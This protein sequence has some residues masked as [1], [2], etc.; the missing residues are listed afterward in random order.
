MHISKIAVTAL[1]GTQ[2]IY[3]QSWPVVNCGLAHDHEYMVVDKKRKFVSQKSPAG[4]KLALLRTHTDH[5][6]DKITIKTADNK[7]KWFEWVPCARDMASLLGEQVE[8]YFGQSE[9]SQWMSEFLKIECDVVKLTDT[10]FTGERR[11]KRIN[12]YWVNISLVD[13]SQFL[14]ISQPTL[15][16]LS[17]RCGQDID[18]RR[19]RPTL[20]I[21]EDY[22]GELEPDCENTW[23]KIR[24]GE[25]HELTYYKPCQRCVVINVNQETGEVDELDL[26]SYLKKE[27]GVKRGNPNF[28]AKFNQPYA[29]FKNYDI[30]H[31][32]SKVEVL[33]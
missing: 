25:S 1:K 18:W 2:P 31:I 32:G 15:D 30:I 14:I 20:I 28:G 29:G 3:P 24:I 27:Q 10:K 19:F 26:L 22:P 16:A 6:G 23:K 17:E 12:D 13:S 5:S 7:V 11:K 33:E 4:R 8:V 21:K 9:F